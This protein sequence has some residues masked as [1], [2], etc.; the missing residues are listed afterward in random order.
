MF[1]CIQ[2]SSKL[3]G[4]GEVWSKKE[5]HIWYNKLIPLK[6]QIY[7]DITEAYI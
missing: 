4:T 1:S 7:W 2:I 5:K 6:Y 3:Y